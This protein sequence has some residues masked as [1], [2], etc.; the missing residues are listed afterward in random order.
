MKCKCG[1][2]MEHILS[3]IWLCECQIGYDGT[4]GDG[5]VWID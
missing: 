4:Y 2:E 5:G 1:L 3:D